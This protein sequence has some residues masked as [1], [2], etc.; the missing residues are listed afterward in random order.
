[1]GLF[2]FCGP[3]ILLY[4][5][6]Y[7]LRT[8]PIEIVLKRHNLSDEKY[9]KRAFELA[10]KGK[11]TVSPNPLV[12]A[13]IVKSDKILS[14]GLSVPIFISLYIITESTLTISIGYL[15]FNFIAKEDFPIAVGPSKEIIFSLLE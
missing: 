14:E 7:Q 6:I 4:D 3:C 9:M 15:F 11:G 10:L 8:S 13:V 1:M 12:G 2:S 5:T